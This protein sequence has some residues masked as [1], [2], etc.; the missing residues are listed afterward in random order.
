M[1]RDKIE[2]YTINNIIRQLSHSSTNSYAG[3]NKETRPLR[4][5][6]TNAEYQR[7]D[8]SIIA[9]G[10]YLFLHNHAHRVSILGIEA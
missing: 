5:A 8:Q 1:N 9:R 6:N 4:G 10:R 7:Q 2:L 3:S